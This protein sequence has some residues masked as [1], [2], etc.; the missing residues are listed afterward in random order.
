MSASLVGSE[1]CIRDRAAGQL[2]GGGWTARHR[3]GSQYPSLRIGTWPVL[4]LCL[5]YTSDAADDM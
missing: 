1:M 5:L 4:E 2:Q 3:S